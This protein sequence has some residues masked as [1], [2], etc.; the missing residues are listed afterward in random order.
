MLITQ[1]KLFQFAGSTTPTAYHQG[2]KARPSCDGQQGN[3]T[4]IHCVGARHN[5][6]D[7]HQRNSPTLC[8]CWSEVRHQ[9]H[10][11]QTTS[12]LQPTLHQLGQ[13]SFSNMLL[14]THCSCSESQLMHGCSPTQVDS[15]TSPGSCWPPLSGGSQVGHQSYPGHQPHTCCISVLCI[16]KQRQVLPLGQHWPP[17][18]A[19][20]SSCCWRSKTA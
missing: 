3:H 4:V 16:T 19:A 20:I 10:I 6:S 11:R 15:K 2:C 7:E 12:R 14:M 13:F 8:E 1:Y 9:H 18:A 17:A 5:A